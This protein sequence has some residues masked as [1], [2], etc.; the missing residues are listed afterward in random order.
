MLSH[1]LRFLVDALNFFLVGSISVCLREGICCW[2]G[3]SWR[4]ETQALTPVEE[5]FHDFAYWVLAVLD[6]GD[7]MAVDGLT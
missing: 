6:Y 1:S 7:G 3:C 4:G 2:I 5:T